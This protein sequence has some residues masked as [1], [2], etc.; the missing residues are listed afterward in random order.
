MIGKLAGGM[1]TDVLGWRTVYLANVPV[2]A[3][4]ALEARNRLK[5][6]RSG[7]SQEGRQRFD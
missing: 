6:L 1:L 3:L 7:S 5:E 4:I 2:A